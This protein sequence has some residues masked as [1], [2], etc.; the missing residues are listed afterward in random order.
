MLWSMSLH[1]IR[2][3]F[4]TI[5]YF[6]VNDCEVKFW[7]E[8]RTGRWVGARNFMLQTVTVVLLLQHGCKIYF[9]SHISYFSYFISHISC[10]RLWQWCCA[11]AKYISSLLQT[12]ASSPIYWRVYTEYLNGYLNI[13]FPAPSCEISNLL[14][15]ANISNQILL[16][17]PGYSVQNFF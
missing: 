17:Y 1:K 16:Q 9:I 10:C 15:R 12:R 4:W 3:R 5:F 13:I 6:W 2:T 8:T 7:A 14:H 11:V